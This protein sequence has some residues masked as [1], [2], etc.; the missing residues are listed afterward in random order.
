MIARIQLDAGARGLTVATL[1][2][3]EVMSS[4]TSDILLAYPPVG[5][6]KLD[7]LVRLPEHLDLKVA[8]D[9][10]EVLVPLA[11][12]AARAG[13]TVG[14][15]VEMD[16]GLGRVGV[17]SEGAVV[18]LARTAQELD[19][20]AYRG[21]LFYPGH[22]RVA[23]AEQDGALSALAD[24]LASVLDVLENANLS[25]EIVSGGST[26]TLWRSHQVPGMTEIRSGSC[27]FF[28]REAVD[29]G[30]AGRD[31]VAY[32]VLATVVSTAVPGRAVVDAGSKALAKEGRGG[33][34]FGILLDH[35]EVVLTALSE[36]H[37]VL[38][39]SA[40]SWK[41]SIGERVRIV[42]NHVCVSVN[43]QDTLL[44]TDAGAHGR[45][46]RRSAGE[47]SVDRLKPGRTEDLLGAVAE[48][49][50]LVV[51]D[52]MLD[53]YIT[54]AVDRIS[55]EAP[56]PVVRVEAESSAVGGA[57]N[58]AANVAALGAT[59]QVVGCAGL[60]ADG[61]H[62]ARGS[63]RRLGVRTEGLVLSTSAPPR[64]RRASLPAASRWYASTVRSRR[65]ATSTLTA[66]LVDRIVELGRVCDVLIM[67][68]YNKGVLVPAG[69][70]GR[71][72]DG[73]R[74]RH[75]HGGRP[76]AQEL[77]RLRG[78]HRLQAQRKELADAL[79][80]FLHPD[81]PEWM[82]AT[83]RRMRCRNLLLTL[84]ERGMALQ[85]WPGISC[86]SRPWPAPSTTSPAPATR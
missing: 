78:R 61:E 7:R 19:G 3:A 29:V 15:L 40:T 4:L 68:D 47:G 34:G 67:E 14:V 53:R 43:L 70:P 22:I 65:D 28:D 41:P 52:L 33:A 27:I 20:V 13:R 21:I 69:H 23:Q 17:Q 35:P 55:P 45:L 8:L 75:P 49:R 11:E 85:T 10:A 24:R 9:S 46:T 63:S 32:T 31:D 2:E 58:V 12:A 72:G 64:S 26:P 50:V 54:G 48:L 81:D 74:P 6:A 44:T 86:A 59:C 16:M 39:L 66:A 79:G 18:A 77:L 25:P 1:R 83:R 30:V 42:P 80:E 36:E 60:D 73:T 71:P 57:A 62:P 38:D 76:E 82:E 5:A 56:V 37:G 51:G 84:G